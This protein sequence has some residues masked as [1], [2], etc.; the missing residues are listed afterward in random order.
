[1]VLVDQLEHV[2]HF[3]FT[4]TFLSGIYKT[5]SISFKRTWNGWT[6]FNGNNP[7]NYSYLVQQ[8]SI[9]VHLLIF[10]LYMNHI[11]WL[12][13]TSSHGHVKC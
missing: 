9:S 10:H 7:H 1:M 6:S 3:L 4:K 11:I 8:T 2:C 13:Y 5:C 12:I